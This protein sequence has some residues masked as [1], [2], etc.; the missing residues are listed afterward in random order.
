MKNLETKPLYIKALAAIAPRSE[1]IIHVLNILRKYRGGGDKRV[2]QSQPASMSLEASDLR[3][4]S[5][6]G[7][8]YLHHRCEDPRDA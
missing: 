6:A 1:P 3:P 2:N 4:R 7:A 5:T 8:P